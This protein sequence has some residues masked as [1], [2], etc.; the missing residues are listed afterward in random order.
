MP[1][2]LVGFIIYA[3]ADYHV[4]ARINNNSRT[5]YITSFSRG[6]ATWLE[7]I[8]YVFRLLFDFFVPALYGVFCMSKLV[9]FVGLG[10]ARLWPGAL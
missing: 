6:R 8:N 3:W 7:T 1:T 9:T 10:I 5:G 4:H 2:P